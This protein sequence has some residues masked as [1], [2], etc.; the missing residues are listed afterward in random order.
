MKD[1]T[2][3][4]KERVDVIVSTRKQDWAHCFMDGSGTFISLCL[5][6]FDRADIDCLVELRRKAHWKAWPCQACI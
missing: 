1:G 3:Y 4:T 5:L 2:P 6:D